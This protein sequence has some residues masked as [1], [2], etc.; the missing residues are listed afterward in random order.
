[1]IADE[2]SEELGHKWHTGRITRWANEGRVRRWNFGG[3]DV[4]SRAE[5][6]RCLAETAGVIDPSDRLSRE[7]DDWLVLS[8]K[9][10]ELGRYSTEREARERLRQIEAAKRAKSI[11]P[12]EIDE[13]DKRSIEPDEI[14]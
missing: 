7:G 2:I 13:A 6:R 5:V 12:D 4:F 14:D 10:R 9:G 8:S 11:E 1:V 3:P